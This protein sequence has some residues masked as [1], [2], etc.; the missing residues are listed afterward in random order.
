MCTLDL[1]EEMLSRRTGTCWCCSVVSAGGLL[2]WYAPAVAA[3]EAARSAS[4]MD[5]D[6]RLT[7]AA[8]SWPTMGMGE[9][10]RGT[11]GW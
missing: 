3:L 9:G 2:R 11:A 10:G 4:R 8:V 1:T 6:R 5:M 7:A